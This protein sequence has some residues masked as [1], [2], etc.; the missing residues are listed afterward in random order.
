MKGSTWFS[1][2]IKILR[3]RSG[4]GRTQVSPARVARKSRGFPILVS[5]SAANALCSPTRINP[6]ESNPPWC[7]SRRGVFQK[8][9][10]IILGVNWMSQRPRRVKQTSLGQSVNRDCRHAQ[11]NC[12][13]GA[14]EAIF[15]DR[16]PDDVPGWLCVS[17]EHKSSFTLTSATGVTRRA[18][19]AACRATPGTL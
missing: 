3:G 15:F 16:H 1:P 5:D 8:A 7:L 10:E 2:R 9:V 4:D 12:G 11:V 17:F 18:E 13:L 14:F 6:C 19:R